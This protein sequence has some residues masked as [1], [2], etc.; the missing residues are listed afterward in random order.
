MALSI[1]VRTNRSGSYMHIRGT[2]APSSG[3]DGML[4]EEGLAV[5]S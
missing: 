1:W 3:E 5:M 2:D 4:Q